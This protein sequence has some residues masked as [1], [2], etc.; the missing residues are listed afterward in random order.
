MTDWD[1]AH[2]LLNIANLARQWPG[3]Q[4]LH[5]AAMKELGSLAPGQRPTIKTTPV[6]VPDEPVPDDGADAE[7]GAAEDVKR[8]RSLNE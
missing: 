3:L 2:R 6:E 1:H 7:A 5:D 8:R 4:W